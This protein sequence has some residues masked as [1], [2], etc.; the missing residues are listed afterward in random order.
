MIKNTYA[1]ERKFSTRQVVVIGLLFAITII[2][3]AT[4]LGFLPIPPFKTTIMHIPVI[5]GAILEGPVV[6]AMIGLLFGLFSIFQAINT[7]TP[8]SFIF[9]DPIV[10][11]LPRILIG[12]T[13]YYGY[14][15]IKTKSK[16]LN[17]GIGAAIGSFTNTLGVVGIIFALYLDDYANAL[18]VSRTFATNTLLG[19]IL[20]GFISAAAAIII[21][22]PV[23]MAVT[24]SKSK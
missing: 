19:L 9:I 22:V 24:R 2:L 17:I 3:G 15:L 14:K 10:A 23:V 21:T 11:V 13:S 12:V 1:S 5:I 8:V 16:T 7:P 20:N 18:H 4:G 6:G